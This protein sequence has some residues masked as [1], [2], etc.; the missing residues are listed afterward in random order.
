MESEVDM[1]AFRPKK[2]LI[3]GYRFIDGYRHRKAD[4]TI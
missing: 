4:C 3:D 1:R 2:Y